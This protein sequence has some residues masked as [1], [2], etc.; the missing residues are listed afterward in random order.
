[1]ELFEINPRLKW[2]SARK[3]ACVCLGK[4]IN[5][6]SNLSKTHLDEV[7]EPYT[8][9]TKGN[10]AGLQ[11][12]ISILDGTER[13]LKNNTCLD[14]VMKDFFSDKHQDNVSVLSIKLV[15]GALD[16]TDAAH[17]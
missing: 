14:A 4:V 3:Q 10:Q 17:Q 5:P 16:Q 15:K 13:A 1:M 8:N 6:R 11:L 9:L 12:R 2:L 7:V